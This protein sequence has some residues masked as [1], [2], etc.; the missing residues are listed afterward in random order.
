MKFDK[1][2]KLIRNKFIANSFSLDHVGAITPTRDGN[3]LAVLGSRI[4]KL[5]PQ[6]DSL[7]MKDTGYFIE[8][9]L[10][11]ID[12]ENEGYYCIAMKY[13]YNYILQ[14]ILQ[15]NLIV[16]TKCKRELYNA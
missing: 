5:T 16:S 14:S 2:N 15:S 6:G 10:I 11:K 9:G 1:H 8:T 3:L 4:L 7:W 12:S 13:I